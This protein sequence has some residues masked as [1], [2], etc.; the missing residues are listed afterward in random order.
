MAELSPSEIANE[1]PYI[2][3]NR[4][5]VLSVCNGIFLAIAYIAILLRFISRRLAKTHN[6]KDDYWIWI[7]LV[8]KF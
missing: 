6:G 1:E 2:D 8:G 3:Q 4:Q 7:A 5:T